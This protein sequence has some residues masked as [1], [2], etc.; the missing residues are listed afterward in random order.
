MD[1]QSES[2]SVI[3]NSR[4]PGFHT[5][6]LELPGLVKPDAARVIQYFIM[7]LQ[8]PETRQRIERLG[9]IGSVVPVQKPLEQNKE[10]PKGSCPPS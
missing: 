4:T 10:D 3:K 7:G 9:K 1:S 6:D 5:S 2:F 8:D